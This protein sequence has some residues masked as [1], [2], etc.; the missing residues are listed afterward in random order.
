MK[1]K[2]PAEKRVRRIY[3]FTVFWM[4]LSMI[5]ISLT[6]GSA[7]LLLAR[8]DSA[9]NL[10][11]FSRSAELYKKVADGGV[12]SPEL[13]YNLGNAY[14]KLNDYPNAIL[15]YE[16]AKKLN[17]GGGDVIFNLNVANTKISDKI[18]PVPEMFYKRWY[19]GVVQAMPADRWGTLS[20]LLLTT[21][22]AG[23]IIFLIT[24]YLWLRKAGFWIGVVFI[25]F[26]LLA[27]L[28]GSSGNR[29]RNSSDEAIVFD[30]TVTVKSSPD[31]NS[32]DI[33]V[34]HEGTKVTIL[35]RIG[36]WYEIRIANGSVGWLPGNSFVRI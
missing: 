7:Q 26:S 24:R 28:F 13:Y 10:G 12:E 35:D 2:R 27:L 5:S 16:R 15:W 8:A 18:E 30:P 21:G 3:L 22:L 20:I 33:F 25:A 36:D 11:D 31:D 29:F 19:R 34:I 6:A 17:P 4:L 1:L 32:T 14:F 9:Y 23:L